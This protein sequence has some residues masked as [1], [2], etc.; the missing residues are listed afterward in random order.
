MFCPFSFDHCV[1]CS[2]SIYGFWL[3][4]WYLQIFRDVSISKDN[5]TLEIRATVIRINLSYFY[6][7]ICAAF[8][9][10]FEY[11]WWV[12]I[13][14]LTLVTIVPTSSYFTTLCTYTG[15]SITYIISTVVWIT[16]PH[17]ATITRQTMVA[18]T[19]NWAWCTAAIIPPTFVTSC[20]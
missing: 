17:T 6:N 10:V 1:I 14:K 8:I 13:R 7:L 15:G 18:N 20:G 19:I 16:T 11:R 12:A 4:L 5:K 3:P 2:S 9:I